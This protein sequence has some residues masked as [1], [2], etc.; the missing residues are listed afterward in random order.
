MI[1]RL[2]IANRAEI[3]VRVLRA[4]RMLEMETVAV[5]SE[6]DRH[7]IH[8]RL[9][10]DAISIGPGSARNNYL[11][12]DKLIEVAHKKEVDAI[13]P[14]YG[15]LSESAEFAQAVIDNDLTWVGPPPGV[16]STLGDKLKAR[17]A[18]VEV[19]VPTTPGTDAPVEPNNEALK[20]A[21]EIG[22]PIMVKAAYGGGGM[23][24]EVVRDEAQLI[25]AIKRTTRQAESAFGK[26]DIFLEKYVERP[27][28]IEIQFMADTKG[29]VVHLGERDCS[30]QRRHQKL[31]EEA[32]SAINDEQR[33]KIGRAVKK[34]ARNVGYENAGTA[35]FL[36]KEGEFFFNEVNAR[37]QVEHPV[38][39]MVTGKDLVIEQLLVAS[40]KRLSWKQKDIEMKGHAI[41]L[42]INAEDPINDFIPSPGKVKSLVMP[43]G[44]GVRFDTHMYENYTVPH[45]YDSLLGKLVIWGENRKQAIFRAYYA[46][47]ELAITGF[48]N[49]AAFHRVVLANK[50]FHQG[51][52]T[53][54]FIDD[55]QLLPYIKNAFYRRVAAAFQ[56]GMRT[57]KIILPNRSKDSKWKDQGKLESQGRI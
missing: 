16:I 29:N 57:S 33:E 4:A 47:S 26:S 22:F 13:H 1:E 37:L 30:I 36:Y 18:A 38:T 3:A 40:G 53:T 17:Q 11:N 28:H 7:C 41:E 24:M 9:A 8:T 56:T 32:P 10:D 43:G 34:L 12:I 19:G 49:N 25:A 27:K 54:N 35:E 45:D 39:E 20:A 15:F 14:G 5:Y 48:P 42:R 50:E 31:I 6:Q 44:F 21:K 2:L 55:S 23:G 52:T 51:K 46:L